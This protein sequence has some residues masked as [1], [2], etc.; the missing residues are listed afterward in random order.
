MTWPFKNY[1]RK[2]KTRKSEKVTLAKDLLVIR[3]GLDLFIVLDASNAKPWR[4]EHMSCKN[5]ISLNNFK[6][7]KVIGAKCSS[8]IQGWIR[9]AGML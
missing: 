1:S 6:D 2:G 5:M 4:K 9:K 7:K 3:L 8:I